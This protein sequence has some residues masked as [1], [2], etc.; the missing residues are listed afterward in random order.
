M[1]NALETRCKR[2]ILL[3][4]DPS[5]GV[6]K[7]VPP[8]Q[9]TFLLLQMHDLNTDMGYVQQLWYDQFSVCLVM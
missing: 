1:Q 7:Y 6:E 2:V 5:W 9:I 8:H 3:A 4:P